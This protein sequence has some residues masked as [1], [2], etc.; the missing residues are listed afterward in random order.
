[1]ARHKVF[2]EVALPTIAGL[3]NATCQIGWGQNGWYTDEKATNLRPYLSKRARYR[4]AVF[5]PVKIG[6]MGVER[7]V[8]T[9]RA[10]NALPV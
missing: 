5:H 8:S 4:P 2:L 7:F 1:M 6:L 3:L 10:F 9:A